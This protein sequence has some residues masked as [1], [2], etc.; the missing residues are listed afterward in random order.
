MSYVVCHCQQYDG[1]V[2]ILTAV[3]HISDIKFAEDRDTDGVYIEHENLVE[4]SK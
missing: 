4:I 3:I 1:V 2:A